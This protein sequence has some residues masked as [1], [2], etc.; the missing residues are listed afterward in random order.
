MDTNFVWFQV[1]FQVRI[2]VL[3][4]D[5]KLTYYLIISQNAEHYERSHIVVAR[6]QNHYSG[7][8]TWY[9]ACYLKHC[10]KYNIIKEKQGC[11]S[12]VDMNSNCL[13][14]QIWK[15]YCLLMEL[16]W[17]DWNLFKLRKKNLLLSFAFWIE[18]LVVLWCIH[19]LL[20]YDFEFCFAW[21]LATRCMFINS[22]IKGIHSC[23]ILPL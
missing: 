7:H 6:G 15:L 9:N 17:G 10:L 23:G 11:E 19:S 14:N 13:T 5:M 16:W 8:Y 1:I 21:M 2:C 18:M 22:C 12:L 4:I 20:R 3:Y